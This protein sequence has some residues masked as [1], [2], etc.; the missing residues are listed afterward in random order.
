[1]PIPLG[2]RKCHECGDYQGYRRY[3]A[4]SSTILSLLIA[5]GSILTLF[6]DRIYDSIREKNSVLFIT[7]IS[8][9]SGEILVYSENFGERP[10]MITGGEFEG[11]LSVAGNFDFAI[12]NSIFSVE[13]MERKNISFIYEIEEIQKQLSDF[14][15]LAKENMQLT[16]G[17][18]IDKECKI[19]VNIVPYNYLVE[20][21]EEIKEYNDIELN[22]RNSLS[23]ATM[24]DLGYIAPSSPRSISY[25]VP[26]DCDVL[27]P[28]GGIIPN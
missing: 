22:L 19:V 12:K 11:W 9:T 13:P 25:P 4:F 21:I 23:R 1:M 5:L 7:P 10:A 27:D 17:F 24:R 6:W 26:I 20:T 15:N 18:S 14:R 3:L 16:K 2:A 8:S 28:V